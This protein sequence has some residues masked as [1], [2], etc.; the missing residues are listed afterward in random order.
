MPETPEPKPWSEWY[1]F[2]RQALGFL[3]DESVEYANL[4]FVEERNHAS[5]RA[6]GKGGHSVTAPRPR[7]GLPG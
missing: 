3:H 1:Y 2:A 4:R 5:L 7:P 6:R